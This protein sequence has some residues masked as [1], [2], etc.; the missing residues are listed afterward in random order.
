MIVGKTGCGKH[1]SYKN[2]K[3]VK[4]EWESS[5]PLSK[6]REAEIQ[7]CFNSKVEFHY[8]KDMKDL[9]ELIETF[10]LRTEN[11]VGN[12]DF[13]S[14][15]S[16]ENKIMDRLIVMDNVSGLGNSC[17]EFADFLTRTRKYRYHCIYVF[18]IVIP[19][20]DIWKKIL[21][22]TNIFNI[23][24]PS[25]LFHTV[26]KILQSNCVPT[27]AKYVPVRSLWINRLFIDLANRD[28]RNSLTI[29]CS[30]TNKNG[31]GSYRTKDDNPEKQI[32]YFNEPQNDQVYNVFISKRIKFGNFEKGIYFKIDPVKSMT[33]SETVSAKKKLERNG[34]SNDRLLER[35]RSPIAGNLSGGDIGK[36]KDAK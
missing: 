17:K 22:Q 33:D 8:S 15:I 16:S 18:H 34:S 28:E 2:C 9:K 14:S 20:R 1:I 13:S 26:S 7:S 29:D 11:L 27:T 21:S 3:I 4:T 23:F 5:I 12:N 31:P 24:P 19:D 32:C 6:S 35:D 36:G 25:D 10:K 30:G